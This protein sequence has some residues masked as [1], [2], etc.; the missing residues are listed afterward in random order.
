MIQLADNYNQLVK[1]NYPEII[2]Y[3]FCFIQKIINFFFYF[4]L[5]E[6]VSNFFHCLISWPKIFKLIKIVFRIFFK[7]NL[8]LKKKF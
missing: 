2:E 5:V 4:I 8:L 1:E 3:F 7:V 6:F